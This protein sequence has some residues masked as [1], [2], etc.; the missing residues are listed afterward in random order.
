MIASHMD[1]T[2]KSV[3]ASVIH[4][5]MGEHYLGFVAE[6]S[7]HSAVS[8]SPHCVHFRGQYLTL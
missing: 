8:P 5:L 4:G 6:I 3:S 2:A 1:M 7:K